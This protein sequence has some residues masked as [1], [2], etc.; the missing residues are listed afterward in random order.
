MKPF[1]LLKHLHI[2]VVHPLHANSYYFS[3]A[4]AFLSSYL[5]L[6]ENKYYNY[7]WCYAFD[8]SRAQYI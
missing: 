3:G 6:N 4:D 1:L 5:L 8:F 2:V 7:P